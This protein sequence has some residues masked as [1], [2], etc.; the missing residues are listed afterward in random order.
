MPSIIRLALI[1]ELPT[2]LLRV[3]L[4]LRVHNCY[5]FLSGLCK[6]PELFLGTFSILK[7]VTGKGKLSKKKIDE[8]DS[9]QLPYQ[10]VLYFEE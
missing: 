8:A 10:N 4:V 7:S 2:Y 3:E 6:T 5:D 9:F 1:I